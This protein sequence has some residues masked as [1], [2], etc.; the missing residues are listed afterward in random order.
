MSLLA[1]IFRTRGIK[2]YIG[3]TNLDGIKS[4]KFLQNICCGFSEKKKFEL[5]FKF[6]NDNLLNNPEE[7]YF[8]TEK[9]RNCLS[10]KLEISPEKIIF[11]PPQKGSIKIPVVFIKDSIKILKLEDLNI[12]NLNEINKAPLFEYIILDE[13]IFDSRYNNKDDNEWGENEKRGKEDY[14]PPKGWIGYGLNVEDNYDNGDSCWL[15]FAGIYENEFA[16]AYYPISEEDDDIFMGY[17]IGKNIETI[18]NYE[19]SNLIAKSVDRKS[20]EREQQT[21]D[22]TILYQDIKI[23]EKQAS[24]IQTD[25]FSFKIIIMCR[26][27]PKKIRAPEDYKEIWI[28]NPNSEEIRPYR[29]LIKFFPKDEKPI[30]KNFYKFYNISKIFSQCLAIRDEISIYNL[31]STNISKNEYP[32]YLYTRCSTPL[33]E[34]LLKKKI[35]IGYTEEQLQSWIWCLHKSL[36]DL[37]VKTENMELVKDNSEVFSGMCIDKSVLNE[38]FQIGRRLYFGK[39]LSTSP[40]RDLAEFYTF[41]EGF[42]FIIKIKN[43]ERSNYCYNIRKISHFR[44]NEDEVLITAFALFQI[45]NIVEREPISEIYLD[46]L[47]FNQAVLAEN[48]RQQNH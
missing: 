16:V 8:Y 4:K 12:E 14:I 44:D 2:T 7:Y 45:T 25:N 33:K 21:G 48:E 30:T 26:V 39:F 29:I 19:L 24:F 18:E 37:S 1:K 42:L 36:T 34:Y 17:E 32:I 40:S 47:G 3:E 20:G 5:H 35:N 31:N 23:A 38:E 41:E 15:C 28:L 6:C 10:Q 43:N 11:G 22:G 46:C 9:L 27:N 13:T